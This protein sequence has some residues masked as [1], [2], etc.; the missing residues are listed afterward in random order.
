MIQIINILDSSQ[1]GVKNGA[2][3]E[4]VLAALIEHLELINPSGRLSQNTRSAM[5][6]LREE[7]WSEFFF[8]LL[9]S[10]E[11]LDY[12]II[13]LTPESKKTL[14]SEHRNN[15]Q[16]AIDALYSQRRRKSPGDESETLTRRND[17][18]FGN[19]VWQTFAQYFPPGLEK[20]SV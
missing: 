11:C 13:N 12:V 6:Q 17:A 19:H 16:V 20:P 14:M 9:N 2:D 10:L 5:L 3:S 15:I 1:S 7:E 18:I 4:A 8:W